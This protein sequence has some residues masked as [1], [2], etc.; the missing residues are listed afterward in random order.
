MTLDDGRPQ[1]PEALLALANVPLDLD[2]VGLRFLP[3]F[4]PT[5]QM[6]T[7]FR[8][9]A[10]PGGAPANDFLIFAVDRE[11]G[12]DSMAFWLARPGAALEEQPVVAIGP[13]TRPQLIAR[14]LASCL[15]FLADAFTVM[16][17]DASPEGSLNYGLVEVAERFAPGSRQTVAGAETRAAEEFPDFQA[18]LVDPTDP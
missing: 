8:D 18:L 13:Y 2:G 6:E 9:L 4:L 3:D 10:V 12:L 16:G 15:W 5:K 14:D 7:W 1:M 17:I 11:E